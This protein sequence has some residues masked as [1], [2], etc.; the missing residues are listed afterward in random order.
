[1]KVKSINELERVSIEE[2]KSLYKMPLTIILENI[3]SLNNI[4]SIFRTSDA[5]RVERIFCCGITG[6]PPNID[7]HKTALGAE[8][9]VDWCYVES[10]DVAL[11]LLK[12]DN[13]VICA[14]EQAFESVSL[15]QL[16]ECLDL[17]KR[18]VLVVGNEVMG[19]EQETIN[20]TDMVIEIPQAGT[21]HS[22]NVSIATSLAIWEFYKFFNFE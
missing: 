16:P 11:S 12:K 2:F 10:V 15:E 9:S 17:N 7:I 1:M 19:V 22:L 4:G 8:E 21:K 20:K 13:T 14:L 5:F 18:Y 6:T 3:R